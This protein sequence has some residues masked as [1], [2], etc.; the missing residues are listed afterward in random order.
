MY[1]F[2]R[3]SLSVQSRWGFRA[4][5]LFF[6]RHNRDRFFLGLPRDQNVP[7]KKLPSKTFY[8]FKQ[9]PLQTVSIVLLQNFCTK[10]VLRSLNGVRLFIQTFLGIFPLYYDTLIGP[11]FPDFQ[12]RT[13]VYRK[14]KIMDPQFYQFMKRTES[15][16]EEKEK[17]LKI[18][19]GKV[20]S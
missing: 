10:V 7:Q 5:V 11:S 1:G 9:D 12:T 19:E 18:P 17:I 16:D 15:D 8:F 20:D 3:L 6:K 2:G 4:V 13:F 14:R